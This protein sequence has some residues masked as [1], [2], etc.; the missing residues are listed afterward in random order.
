MYLHIKAVQVHSVERN[1]ELEVAKQTEHR[2]G[3]PLWMWYATQAPVYSAR[4]TRLN[5]SCTAHLVVLPFHKV[6]NI[7][8]K[9]LFF[10]GF[11]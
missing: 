2:C 7:R 5:T 6:K 10:A 3:H 11:L 1:L 9:R 8:P 4:L